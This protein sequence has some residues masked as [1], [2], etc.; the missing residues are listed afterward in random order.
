MRQLCG[1]GAGGSAAGIAEGS[2]QAFVSHQRRKRDGA[3]ACA[4]PAEKVAAVR[5]KF[6]V[7]EGVHSR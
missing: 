3:E 1:H 6:V 5:E 2:Q 7:R 4:T